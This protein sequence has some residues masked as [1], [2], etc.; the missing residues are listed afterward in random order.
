MSTLSPPPK[1]KP[2][3]AVFAADEKRLTL[4]LETFNALFGEKP[5]VLS[6]PFSVDQTAFY[7]KE[8]GESLIKVYASWPT[9]IPPDHLIDIKLAAMAWETDT[10]LNNCRLA[11]LDPGY[12]STGAFVLSTAKGRGHR[13]Y[14]GR[15]VWGEL[16]L[17]YHKGCFQSFPWTYLDYMDSQVQKYLVKMRALYIEAT[18]RAQKACL[19]KNK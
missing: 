5:D 18:V 7:K 11:N 2:F 17:S 15:G 12:I 6:P 19:T 10:A 14:L 8:M 4:G 9:L 1:V 16:T 3:A 13:L